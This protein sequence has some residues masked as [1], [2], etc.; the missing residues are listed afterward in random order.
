VVAG[1]NDDVFGII[2]LNDVDVLIQRIGGARVPGVAG[3]L[4]CRQNIETLIP[5]GPEE[6][7][8]AL[9]MADQT[10]CLVLRGDA[11]P[12]DAGVQ[13]VRQREVDDPALA[14]EIYAGLAR[15]SVSSSSREPRPP[16]RT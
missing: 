9:Q 1:E 10:V 8:A 16:A 15:V 14:A 12:P 3:A 4:R 13:R 6:V 5:L 7:P 2:A 11:D